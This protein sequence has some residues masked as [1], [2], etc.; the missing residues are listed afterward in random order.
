MSADGSVVVF[1][2][3]LLGLV[4]G[5]EQEPGL[6]D[7]SFWPPY[8]I[9]AHDLRTGETTRVS[10]NAAGEPGNA[11]SSA[12]AISGDGS[13]VAFQSIAS[14]LV[15]GVEPG[16][17]LQLF[18]ADRGT[19]EVRLVSRGV[20][21]RPGNG[22]VFLPDV[23]ADGR[24]VV[25]PSAASNL[26]SG[27]RNE[28]TDMFAYD[29]DTGA[30]ELVSVSTDGD[31]QE[32]QHGERKRANLSGEIHV[33]V[34]GDGRYV[35]FQSPADNLSARDEPRAAVPSTNECFDDVFVRDRQAG[36]TLLVSVSSRGEQANNCNW[37]AGLSPS[38]AE[39][40][41]LSPA[42]NLVDDDTNGG[43]DLF[44]HA[45]GGGS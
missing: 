20:D 34:S 42:D 23:S 13:L 18:L 21:G 32:I 2:S 37:L 45:F 8:H 26:V 11:T 15:P 24:T 19:G 44:V 22:R 40:V 10:V 39:V 33:R 28:L 16:E 27:D 4:D 38:G 17:T 29:V 31:Q 36:T 35:A 5:E 41:F 1:E 6:V 14:N 9:Y 7:A 43:T 30:I 12:P 3:A 25:F